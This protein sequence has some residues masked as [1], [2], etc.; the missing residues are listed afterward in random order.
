MV[1]TPNKHNLNL[2]K[3]KLLRQIREIVAKNLMRGSIV[4][5]RRLCGKSSCVCL[6]EGKKHKSRSLSVNLE[7]ST[8]WIY[9]NEER[10]A[11]VRKLTYN[12]RRLWE[13][14]D[15]LTEVNL[16]L[17]SPEKKR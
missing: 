4:E 5:T 11:Q 16:K 7:G 15:R 8:R 3:N 14:L 6:R 17:L 12:Y 2:Q 13:L 10:E 1:L 9:L